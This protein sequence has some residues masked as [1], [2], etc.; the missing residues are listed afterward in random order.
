MLYVLKL[1]HI[2]YLKNLAL[3]QLIVDKDN[4]DN[5]SAF[6]KAMFPWLEATEK[7]D[8]A[9]HHEALMAE[10]KRGPF[11]VRSM[12]EPRIQSRLIKRVSKGIS[13]AEWERMRGKVYD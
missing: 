6:K 5:F 2:E 12:A 11:S 10:V 7:R 8:K 3:A 9:K 4:T 13:D 1:Q